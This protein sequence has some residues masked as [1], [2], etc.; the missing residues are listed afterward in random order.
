MISVTRQSWGGNTPIDIC[1]YT[2]GLEAV[3]STLHLELGDRFHRNIGYCT[4]Y[5]VIRQ[6]YITFCFVFEDVGTSSIMATDV[7]ATQ[8]RRI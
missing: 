7:H 2:G 5:I 4:F 1:R 8:D 3:V 6:A